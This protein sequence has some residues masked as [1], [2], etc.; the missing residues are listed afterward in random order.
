MFRARIGADPAPQ[1]DAA[2]PAGTVSAAPPPAA[3]G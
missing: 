1:A 2:P 3:E